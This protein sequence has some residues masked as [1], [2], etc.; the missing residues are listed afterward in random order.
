[1]ASEIAEL[2]YTLPDD[3]PEV[4]DR[5]ESLVFDVRSGQNRLR[6]GHRHPRRAA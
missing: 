2:G 1:V 4:L 6:G 3:I 5:A